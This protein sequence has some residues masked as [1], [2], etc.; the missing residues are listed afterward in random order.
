MTPRLRISILCLLAAISVFSAETTWAQ[1]STSSASDDASGG[2]TG[3]IKHAATATGHFV[4]KVTT[5][6][7]H[8][9]KTGAVKTGEAIG[10]AVN[11]TESKLENAGVKY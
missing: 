3:R 7:G 8:A 1:S 6:T 11:W 9:L 4:E 10:T 2:I 5:K